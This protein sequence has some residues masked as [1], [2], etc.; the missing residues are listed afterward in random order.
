VNRKKKMSGWRLTDP[1]LLGNSGMSSGTLGTGAPNIAVSR[2]KRAPSVCDNHVQPTL[3]SPRKI[4]ALSLDEPRSIQHVS[5]IF[6]FIYFVFCAVGWLVVCLRALCRSALQV[7]QRSILCEIF[8]FF[9]FFFFFFQR[10]KET[11]CARDRWRRQ[12]NRFF[13]NTLAINVRA[14]CGTTKRGDAMRALFF[15]E[16]CFIFFR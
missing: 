12:A 16:P 7:A 15:R 10:L 5:F 14:L 8:F 2:K 6:L 3:T 9:F 1:P 11:R 4:A 13:R